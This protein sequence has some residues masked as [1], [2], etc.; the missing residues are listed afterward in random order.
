ML[1]HVPVVTQDQWAQ[2]DMG[3]EYKSN[4]P[5]KKQIGVETMAQFPQEYSQ[6]QWF[7]LWVINDEL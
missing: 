7:A 2:E 4:L 3:P 6:E 5:R 1:P